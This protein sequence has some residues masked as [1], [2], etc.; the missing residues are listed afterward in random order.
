LTL[1][2]CV[3]HETCGQFL[4]PAFPCPFFRESRVLYRHGL[5]GVSARLLPCWRG[6][7]QVSAIAGHF[8]II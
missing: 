7:R 1:K 2:L 8:S 6:Y 4:P 3:F 5:I